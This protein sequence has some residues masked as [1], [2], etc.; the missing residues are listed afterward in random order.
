MKPAITCFAIA[1]ALLASP[2]ASLH[3]ARSVA[4]SVENRLTWSAAGR[5]QA[6]CHETEVIGGVVGNWGPDPVRYRRIGQTFRCRGPRLVAVQLG[7]DD[8][9]TGQPGLCFTEPVTPVI[10]SLR[11]GGP[12]GEVVAKTTIQPAGWGTKAVL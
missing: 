6:T 10:L 5:I 8:F 12:E 4:S 11:R 3:A 9:A 7:I 1:A 2:R